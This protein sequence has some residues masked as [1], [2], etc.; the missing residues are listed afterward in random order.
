MIELPDLDNAEARARI[1]ALG[2]RDEGECVAAL[3]EQASLPPDQASTVAADAASLV[4]A[5]RQR[6][7]YGASVN[8]LLNEYSL[9]SQEGVLLMCLAEALLRVP[10]KLTTDR[11]ISDKLG[12][13]DWSAHLG[14]SHSLFVNASAWGLLL[15]GKVVGF[16]RLASQGPMDQLRR[17]VGQAGEP[18][19]RA[20]MRLAM[21]IMGNQFVLGTDIDEALDRSETWQDRGYSYT[22]DML[23]EAARTGDYARDYFDSYCRAI[24]RVGSAAASQSPESG[25][26][27]SIKL[28]ALHPRYELAHYKRLKSELAPR[29][30]ELAQL[31]RHHNLGLTLDAEEAHRLDPLLEIFEQV[32]T[33]PSL[34]GWEGLG[35]AV[36]TY[37][38][39][40]PAV[41]DWLLQ[42]A[43]QQRR[44][45]MVR[46]VKGAY[47]DAEI[48]LA[49]TL[50]YDAYPVYTR[51]ASSDLAYI[52]GARALLEA[53]D[54]VFPQFATHNAHSVAAILQLAGDTRGYEF[55]RLHG[56]GE[57][58]YDEL[59]DAR[60]TPAACRIYAPVGVHKDLLAYLVR[61]LLE[62]GANSSFVHKLADDS[63]PDEKLAEDPAGILRR[64][65]HLANPAI[66]LPRDIY[67]TSRAAAT[68]IDLAD[69]DSLGRIAADLR[70]WREQV[71]A[72]SSRAD[73]PGAVAVRDPA[74]GSD[75][76]GHYLPSS[77]AEIDDRLARARTA[78]AAWSA[79]PVSRRAEIICRAAELMERH[80]HELAGFC[81]REAGKTVRDAIADVREAVDF[82]RYYAREAQSLFERAGEPVA[83]RGVVLC[84]SPWNFPVAIFVGQVSAALVT[85]NAVLAKPAEQ[86]TLTGLRVAGLFHE[87]GVPDD[88]LQLVRG[89]G[90]PIGARL[91]PYPGVAAVMFT[92]ST[93]VARYIARTLADREGERVPLIAETGG[94]NAMVVD[95]TALLEKVVDDVI[96]S[97]FNSA[98]QR[99][100]ALRVLF[101]QADVAEPLVTMLVG[102]MREL[103]VGDP[104]D[105]ATDV[106]PIIDR[107]ALDRLQSHIDYLEGKGQLLYRCP[108]DDTTSGGHFFAPALYE[109]ASID[110]LPREVFGPI[111]HLIRFPADELESLPSVINSTGYGLTFGVHSRI[112]PTIELLSNRVQAGNIYVNRNIIGAVVGVQPFGGHGLSG[113]GPKAGG[114]FYLP[115]LVR[116]AT[117]QPG[118]TA[119]AAS[120]QDQPAAACE[121]D[122]TDLL[123]GLREASATWHS[124]P[125]PQRIACAVRLR[126]SFIGDTGRDLTQLLAAI[127]SLIAQAGEVE[128]PMELAGPTGESNTLTLEPR[129]V[130]VC[131]SEADSQGNDIAIPA[132]AALLAGNTILIATGGSSPGAVALRTRLVDAGFPAAAVATVADSGTGVIATLIRE[133]AIAAV[134]T[135]GNNED[136]P[137]VASRALAQREG[138]ILPLFDDP[139]SRHYLT[140]FCHERNVSINTTASGGNADLMSQ[141]ESD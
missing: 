109:L 101:V 133:G 139:F 88:V 25:P 95:S 32:Y 22:Y 129:G 42:L 103:Q 10:D 132:I 66:P 43:R 83:P 47:W 140:R 79:L 102:A 24:E 51:K 41:I 50:G 89:P 106:G 52:A 91:L 77:P 111:V 119:P 136:L 35:I 49:Q 98:G 58:L 5:I 94:Q 78:F 29:V 82:C 104:A 31:A 11:L 36:Q 123:A 99:C 121:P 69:V 130:V 56:M 34:R 17:T 76:I 45:I 2:R 131:L 85:G 63:L 28:S 19:I 12:S 48:K 117:D 71:S 84:I 60:G 15:T 134:A 124:T 57:E 6:Q 125:M 64:F 1:R 44:K 30:L 38:K 40:A 53:R 39:N 90:E 114:P 120:V 92:G 122:W 74:N 7:H 33:D 68:G 14:H 70:D 87:A 21:R 137:I 97:G 46:L 67:G 62:N 141:G 72:V 108:L 20:A 100:S 105:L 118:V 113:T 107:E 126:N 9:S 116:P 18:A 13:G 127:D 4:H 80:A 86:T 73:A 138:A 135:D 8:A 75:I 55:Q 23:G 37:L 96:A 65:E 27:F 93:E 128:R 110:L 54:S 81:V 59:I 112:E 16:Q 61:R 115:R 3:L 26:G